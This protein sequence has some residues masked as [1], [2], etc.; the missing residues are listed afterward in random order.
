M[1]HIE[2]T[3][4]LSYRRTN[5]PWALAIYQDLTSHGYDVFF[6]YENIASGD[7]EQII[8]ENIRARAHFIVLLT[9]SALERCEL[10]NDWLRR[11][12]ETAL[13][14]KRNIVPIFLEGFSFGNPDISKYLTGKRENL[15]KYN[16]QNIPAGFFMEAMDRIR[17][18][19]LN[20]QL[21]T[22]LHPISKA[23]QEAV[24]LQQSSIA[25]APAVGKKE[26]TAQEWF[27]KGQDTNNPEE[28]IGHVTKAISLQ[29]DFAEAYLTRGIL[30][31]IMGNE[32][33]AFND[34]NE[35]IR[36]KPSYSRA[37]LVRGNAYSNNADT[38]RA[39]I[40]FYDAI[41]LEPN[42]APSYLSRGEAYWSLGMYDEAEKD[43]AE[44][45]RL[46]PDYI[47]S[48]L[49][50]AMRHLS[51]KN[52]DKA[53][54][55]FTEVIRINPDLES[56]YYERALALKAKG[57]LNGAI[58]DLSTILRIRPDSLNVYMVRG[59]L[60]LEKKEYELAAADFEKYLE[61]GGENESARR[62]LKNIKKFISSK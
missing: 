30:F 25:N 50:R 40:D 33:R 31:S 38:R 45:I 19:F 51:L 58:K 4:F 12:I 29:P 42:F 37:Y 43:Y 5:M 47:Y 15:K 6:D 41:R 53:I 54:E 2:K 62:D 27:E 28:S 3:V 23:A 26:L 21:E 60:W 39:L 59:Q 36:L 16:G 44:A 52:L 32:E 61:L 17:N 48:Y 57:D 49:S 14:E 34:Y 35:A 55:D 11:E 24:V 7:F 10:P 18:K 8:L 46:E 13:D 22:V 9:P 1:G 56:P 20:V